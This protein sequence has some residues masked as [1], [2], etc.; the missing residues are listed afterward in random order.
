M[1]SGMDV[2]P[3]SFR[4]FCRHNPVATATTELNVGDMYFFKTDNVH[5]APGFGGSKCR[6]VFC[7]FIGYR[8]VVLILIHHAFIVVLRLFCVV[9][10]HQRGRRRGHGLE[11]SQ[12]PPT[13]QLRK[14]ESLPVR[15]NCSMAAIEYVFLYLSTSADL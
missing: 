13:E 3:P 4:E 6:V 14:H 1:Q 7:T 11:L 2:H 9:Y 5:E 12:L 15:T 10:V 8:Y